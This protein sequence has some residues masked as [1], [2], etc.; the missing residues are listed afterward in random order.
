M[1]V[2][3]FYR[4]LCFLLCIFFWQCT[5]FAQVPT[6]S[7]TPK[8]I[9]E[10]EANLIHLGDL[11]DVDVVG[12]FEYD[13]R[14]TISPEGFLSG[15]NFV[16]A[17]IFALCRNE[18]DVAADI[19]KAFGKVLREPKIIVKILDRSNR[20]VSIINGAVKTPQRFQI[21]RPIY[22]NEMIIIS[23]GLTDKTSGD[24]QIFRPQNLS[25]VS[26]KNLPIK[27]DGENRERFAA[28]SQDN[29]SQY[30]NIK[31]VDLL[32][33]KK[34]ANP[35]ILNGDIVTI[36]E[37]QSIYVIGGVA[38]PKQISYRSQIT[39]SRAIDSAGGL[40]KNADAKKITI[41]RREG[42][43]TKI[44][45]ADLEKIR[46]GKAEDI[47]LQASDIVEVTQSGR[48]KRKYPPIINLY[49]LTEANSAKLPLRVVD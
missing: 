12:S 16:E 5:V 33:G 48:E 13:W 27:A 17:P 23:G 36:L 28:A 26:T 49:D 20:A 11:I 10:A 31:I 4:F 35:L 39:L 43:E 3:K 9:P 40:A 7:E 38:N 8:I 1:K 15:L 41:F 24:I 47:N 29:G 45:D 37:A 25:C 21:R 18:E 34:E 42:A 2:S 44:I 14:G 32:N 19:T 30:L 6:P 46:D 22:L